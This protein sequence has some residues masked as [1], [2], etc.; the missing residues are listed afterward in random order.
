MTLTELEDVVET[1]QG[2]EMQRVASMIADAIND[3]PEE[4]S[5]EVYFDHVRRLT[6]SE[7]ITKHALRRYLDAHLLSSPW[8][9]ESLSYLH[10]A[11]DIMDIHH[12]TWAQLFAAIHLSN[13]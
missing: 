11:R 1:I 2:P 4:V 12:I 13:G 5:V 10:E 6:G 8:I 9:C 7:D 3:Y